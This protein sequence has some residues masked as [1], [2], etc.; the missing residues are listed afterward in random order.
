MRR[1]ATAAALDAPPHRRG[2]HKNAK[3][4]PLVP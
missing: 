4:R 2:G 3:G 1:R